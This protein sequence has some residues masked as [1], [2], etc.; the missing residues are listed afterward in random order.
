MRCV[1]RFACL[2]VVSGLIGASAASAQQREYAELPGWA[3]FTAGPHPGN[4]SGVAVE[5]SAAR[6]WIAARCGANDCSAN[7]A[8]APVISLDA[9]T[10]RPGSRFGAGQFVW[11]HGIHVDGD[12]NIWVTDGRAAEGKGMQVIKYAP[13]GRE[14]MRLGH[15]GVS[16]DGPDL[17]SGPTDVAVAADGSVYVTDGHETESNHRV[18]R[19]SSTGEY[20]S[21]FGEFGT[22]PG[23]FNVPHAIAI[24]SRGRLFVADRDNNRVQIFSADGEFI[25]QWTQFGRPS[26]IAIGADDTLYVSDNQSNDERHAGVIRG[27]RIGSA[28]TGEVYSFI[29]DPEFDPAREQETGAHAVAVDASGFLYG[30]EVWGQIVKKYGRD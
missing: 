11:P 13:D 4:V 18:V 15:A 2:C 26:G 20:L 29:P 17:F 24:D 30:A 9:Q 3:D 22:G 5:P 7:P 10:G 6:I 8:V 28:V 27:I 21:S 25:D 1:S 12:G 23:Q 14:L 16:G 19:F